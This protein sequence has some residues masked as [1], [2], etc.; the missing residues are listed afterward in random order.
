MISSKRSQNGIGSATGKYGFEIIDLETG[1]T[2][3]LNPGV[4]YRIII[5]GRY[6]KYNQAMSVNRWNECDPSGSS[7]PPPCDREEEPFGSDRQLGQKIDGFGP[8]FGLSVVAP[9]K[10]SNINL[11][12]SFSYSIVYAK[13]EIF[14]IFS[15]V[16]SAK[17]EGEE[18][19]AIS[20]NSIGMRRQNTNKGEIEN[21]IIR[22]FEIECGLQYEYK[23]SEMTMILLTGGYRYSAHL[24]ALNSNGKSL[25]YIS[26]DNPIATNYGNRDDDYILQGPFVKVGFKF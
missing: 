1:F 13:K 10:H 21:S 3:R 5:G 15:R 19:F 17:K 24:G 4:Y 2:F 12:G 25:K 20:S 14:D 6:A 23:I 16:D 11:I 26:G 7:E 18:I 8:R 9:I 22:H